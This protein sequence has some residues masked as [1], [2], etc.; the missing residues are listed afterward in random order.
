MPGHDVII[1][2]GWLAGLC[3]AR[4]LHESGGAVLVLESS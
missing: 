2:G 3:C 4:H 1:I